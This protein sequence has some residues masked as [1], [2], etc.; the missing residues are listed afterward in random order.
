[1]RN[2][3]A[4]N[5]TRTAPPCRPLRLRGEGYN[6]LQL[7]AGGIPFSAQSEKGAGG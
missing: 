5:L 1:M 4:R 3:F 2:S 6:P 7:R